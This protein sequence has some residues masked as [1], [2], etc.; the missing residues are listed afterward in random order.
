M[1]LR[2]KTAVAGLVPNDWNPNEMDSEGFAELVEE[3]RH[4]GRLPKP[5]VV[6]SNGDGYAIV[7]GEHGWQAAKEVGLAEV[8]VEVIEADDFEA[9]RQTYKRNQH[10][11]HNPVKLGQMFERMLDSRDISIRQLAED[12]SISEGTVRNN[13]LY[14]KAAALRNDY[15]FEGLTVRQVRD[16]LYLPKPISD[17]WLNAGADSKA[18]DEYHK[19]DE[20]HLVSEMCLRDEHAAGWLRSIIEN[21]FWDSS[22]HFKDALKVAL[23]LETLRRGMED[24]FPRISEYLRVLVEADFQAGYCKKLIE[25]LPAHGNRLLVEPGQWVEIFRRCEEA[26]GGRRTDDW[27][28]LYD[29]SVELA[30]KDSGVDLED[31]SDLRNELMLRDLEGAPNFIRN[32]KH[33]K[34]WEKLKLHRM[35]PWPP[36]I[37]E[38]QWDTIRRQVVRDIEGREEER[39]QLKRQGEFYLAAM[40]PMRG[41]GQEIEVTVQNI[42]RKATDRERE[43][44]RSSRLAATEHF[45]SELGDWAP[46]SDRRV[47]TSELGGRPAL[48]VL[49]E[50]VDALPEPEAALLFAIAREDIGAENI[51]FHAVQRELEPPNQEDDSPEDG[52]H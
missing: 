39:E 12:V 37:S 45:F 24:I 6:R 14:A 43:T 28:T 34:L 25:E 15:A 18:L 3:V 19:V 1:L 4:L 8:D 35:K 21:G 27:R 41:V 10:G 36:G 5:V 2:L 46:G 52:E 33:L 51:W 38:G 17:S 48:E 11:E 50:R 16:Y 49:R 9:M 31:A 13:L 40:I 20:R 42:E 7:D 23:Q 44:L 22:A 32:A 47:S 29:Y 26:T 30:A